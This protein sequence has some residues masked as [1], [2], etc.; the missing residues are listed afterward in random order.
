MTPSELISAAF[1]ED[2]PHGDLTTDSLE[3]KDVQGYAYL[4]AKKDALISGQEMFEKSM[5]FIDETLE[6][7]WF[8]EDGSPILENQKACRIKGNLLNVLKAERVALNFFAH[9]SGIATLTHIFVHNAGETLK[10]LDTRKTL[11]G[12]RQMAKK[13]VTDGGGTNHRMNL[14]DA[15]LIKENHVRVAGGLQQAVEQVR[16]NHD[17]AIEVETTNLEEV[18]AAV[19]LNVERIMLDNMSNDQLKE[20]LAAIPSSTETEASGN[21]TVSRVAELSQFENLNYVSVG[22]LTHSAPCADFSLLFEWPG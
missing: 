16:R 12:Y 4:V 17:G 22:A 11:P 15:V 19:A 20:A 3:K 18:Q 10:V 13:A 1:T 21:M 7:Q 8:F 2:L 14:S 9:L 6:L 5:H